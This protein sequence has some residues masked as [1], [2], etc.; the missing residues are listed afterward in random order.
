MEGISIS[1]SDAVQ[2]VAS[3]HDVLLAMTGV[4]WKGRGRCSGGKP[5]RAF[6]DEKAHPSAGGE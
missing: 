5:P 4:R 3:S 1:E 2:G 6:S